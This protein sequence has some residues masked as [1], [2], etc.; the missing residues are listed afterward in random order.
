VQREETGAYS[1]EWCQR[2]ER[3]V[4]DI[5]RLLQWARERSERKRERE[6]KNNKKIVDM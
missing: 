5:P 4:G 3:G 2:R 6:K 1:E